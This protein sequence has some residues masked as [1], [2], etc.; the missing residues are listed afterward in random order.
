MKLLGRGIEGHMG[1]ATGGVGDN[2]PPLLGPAWYRVGTGGRSNENDLCIHSRQP[3]FSTVQVT[4]I[5]AFCLKTER[6]NVRPTGALS[7][8]ILVKEFVMVTCN[9]RHKIPVQT[10][11]GWDDPWD[12]SPVS[13]SV[14]LILVLVL[15]LVLKDSLRTKFKS[16]S[17]SLPLRVYS[18]CPCPCRSSPSPIL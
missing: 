10:I 18:P 1:G 9:L 16:L 2:V 6:W 8:G 11:S 12:I 17:L 7:K 14:M 5:S 15:V 4:Y 3:L 13:M